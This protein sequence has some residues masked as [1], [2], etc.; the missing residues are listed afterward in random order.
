MKLIRSKLFLFTLALVIVAL[1]IMI[2][3]SRGGNNTLLGKAAGAVLTPLENGV[4]SVADWFADLFG[5]FYRY[6]ALEEENT[7]LKRQV[8]QFQQLEQEYWE[9]INEVEELRKLSRISAKHRDFVLE[10]A[11]VIS[12][13][14][15]GFQSAFLINKGSVDGIEIDDCVITQEGEIQAVIGYVTEV[16]PNYA[17]VVTLLNMESRISAVVSRTRQ[18]VVA[19]GDFQ[20]AG[21]GFL[22]VSYLSR[23]ADVKPGDWIETSGEGE[24]YPKGIALGQ[25]E[26]L[27]LESNGMTS[28]ATIRPV[29]DLSRLKGVVV[30]KEFS[31]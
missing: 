23:D 30:V 2:F 11:T 15:T 27:G 21:Q 1:T 9:A 4:S 18:V 24:Y 25:V 7:A 12:I 5:Y 17:R 28:Y 16:G 8:A 22:K 19:E 3:A 31:Q 20:L 26:E 13:D 6:S 10:Q 14:G 29:V